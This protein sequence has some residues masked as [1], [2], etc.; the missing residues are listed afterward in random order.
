MTICSYRLYALYTPPRLPAPC[1][2]TFTYDLESWIRLGSELSLDE[3]PATLHF[4]RH[5]RNLV[6]VI[7]SLFRPCMIPHLI[8]RDSSIATVISSYITID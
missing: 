6:I 3:Q 4:L 1:N 8:L 2:A 7:R 5:D